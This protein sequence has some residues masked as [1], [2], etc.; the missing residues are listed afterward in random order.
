MGESLMFIIISTILN[1]ILISIISFS[2]YLFLNFNRI[3]INSYE[4]YLIKLD[5]KVFMALYN[6]L[7][8]KLNF[9]E[10]KHI[11]LSILKKSDITQELLTELSITYNTN[12]KIIL[13]PEKNSTLE[14]KQRKGSIARRITKHLM[15]NKT[16]NFSRGRLIDLM[17]Q[18]SDL[19]LESIDISNYSQ[20]DTNEYISKFKDQSQMYY[21]EGNAQIITG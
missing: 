10:R 7:F 17:E 6:N 11:F 3:L 2:V 19:L 1:I 18:P 12:L 14:K 8:T 20:T 21:C 5:K 15:S 16:T 4:K 13:I 9:K